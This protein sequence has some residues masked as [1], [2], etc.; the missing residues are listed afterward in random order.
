MCACGE[1]FLDYDEWNVCKI[2]S[3]ISGSEECLSR[4]PWLLRILTFQVYSCE[5]EEFIHARILHLM[6]NSNLVETKAWS[7]FDHYRNE[8]I[9][10]GLLSTMFIPQ[11]LLCFFLPLSN[12]RIGVWVLVSGIYITVVCQNGAMCPEKILYDWIW[13]K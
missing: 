13:V 4:L 5:S 1:V 6:H 12:M 8:Q 11:N 2:V 9:S 7:W 10:K 3:L